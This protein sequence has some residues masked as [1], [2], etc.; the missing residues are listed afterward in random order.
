[1]TFVEEISFE[2]Q[3]L[4]AL[5]RTG[6]LDTPREPE[7]NELVELAAAICGVSMSVVSLVDRHRQWFKAAKGI[8]VCETPREISFCQHAI[9][10]R[11]I[12]SIEDATQDARFR[13]NPFVACDNGVRFYAGV[14]IESPDGFPLGT[15][16]VFDSQP[17]RL[18][19]EQQSALT[20]LARQASARIELRLQ[21]RQLEHAL[22]EAEAA[23]ER[24]AASERRFQTFMNHGPFLA[25]LKDENR[26]YLFYNQC[27]ANLFQISLTDWLGKCD[28]DL[29][30]SEFAHTYREN[31]LKV[32]EQHQSLTAL[33]KTSSPDGGVCTWRSYKF[34]CPGD[35]A[36]TLVGG[37]SLDVT[38]ELAREAELHRSKAS[39]EEANRLLHELAAKDSLTGLANRRVFEERLELEFARS[40]RKKL[41]LAVLVID[42]D[43]FKSRNDTHGHEHGD[44]ILRRLGD[45]LNRTVRETDLAARYGG[46]EFVVLLP[47]ADEVQSLLLAQRIL[48]AIHAEPW[49]IAPITVSIGAAGLTAATPNPQRLVTLADEALY[50][51][52]RAGKDRAVSYQAYYQQIVQRLKRETES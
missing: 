50:A 31:D 38:E 46:E 49:E 19:P 5:Y 41:D 40:R 6:L 34:P 36:T 44:Q 35:N 1:M 24:L 11:H 39:L 7:F 51:A 21:R 45:V 14:P 22:A 29:S 20:T 13:D 30:P 12:F 15:L 47:E 25:F 33:E 23:K 26:R 8:P 10:Q 16:C 2:E 3:R 32:I 37:F 28:D 52:K 18:T 27:F 42:V 48:D 17:R 4:E 43:N 9:L